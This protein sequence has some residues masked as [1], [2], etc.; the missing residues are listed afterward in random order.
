MRA[1]RSPVLVR[2]P[3]SR[4]RS[5]LVIALAS[6]LA[7]TLAVAPLRAQF[8][9]IVYDPTNFGN[10][11][12]RYAELQ[13]Q[14]FQL[15]QTYQQMEQQATKVP[16]EMMARYRPTAVPWNLLTAVDRLERIGAWVA[17]ANTGTNIPAAYQLAT[18]PLG[19]IR[20]ALATIPT[21]EFDDVSA[22]YG[23]VELAD[24][25]IQNGLGVV[26][27]VRASGTAGDTVLQDLQVDSYSDDPAM[28][29]QVAVLNKINA[30]AL[31]TTQASHDSTQVLV[32][33][34]EQ[35]LIAAKGTRD[36][37]AREMNGQIA[38]DLQAQSTLTP[39]VTGTTAIL[40]GF[41]FP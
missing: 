33:V 41:R 39:A 8:G 3:R 37:E 28:N 15:V 40:S 13:R 14:Y 34:L 12:L 30:A 23:T 18:V 26:G 4:R 6:G 22:T 16:V 11:L 7:A 25:A 36:A 9:G 38:F 29:T 10:A 35:Q 19:D 2:D 31:L 21:E 24:G 20:P 5:I 1:P 17:A 32:S 27:Q